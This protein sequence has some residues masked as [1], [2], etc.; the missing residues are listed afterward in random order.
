MNDNLKQLISALR[1]GK[2]S[3]GRYSLKEGEEYCCLGVA[4]DIYKEH[5]G[6]H[7]TSPNEEFETF[8]DKKHNCSRAEPPEDVME[9]YEMSNKQMNTL[10]GLNDESRLTFDAIADFIEE[11]F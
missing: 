1:S 11:K 10:M 5:I 7:W 2:Y 3:Q 4:C 6:G 8:T 9:W